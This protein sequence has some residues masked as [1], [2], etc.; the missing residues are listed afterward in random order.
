VSGSLT[1]NAAAT[2]EVQATDFALS[3]TPSS[4]Q[5]FQ[6]GST[7][8]TAT[9]TPQ[10]GFTG[11]VTLGTNGLPT[12]VSAGFSVSTLTSGDS[13]LNLTVS[14]SV[15]PGSYPF[16]IT[17]VSGPITHTAAAT[18]NVQATPDFAVTVTPGTKKV[19]QG[20]H[21]FFTAT[22]TPQ[23]GFSDPVS[24]AVA[25]LPP[26]ATGSF[27]PLVLN[28]GNSTLSIVVGASVAP[29]NYPLDIT[30]AS[31]ILVRNVHVA[32]VVNVQGS[33]T[34]TIEPASQTVTRSSTSTY[35][36]T[37]TPLNGF[38][39]TVDLAVKGTNS[40]I[41]ASLDP[42]SLGPSGTSTLTVNVDAKAARGPHALRVVGTS[43]QLSKFGT[44]ALTVQ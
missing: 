20:G 19:F 26:G 37:V 17:A 32:L 4:Q 29:G 43:G 5:V 10:N 1:H 22:V 42:T 40:H 11:T 44:L 16:T 23:N 7:S 2:L 28:S 25:G 27:S 24:M 35:T 15:T 34:V 14:N 31:G 41:S 12:G 21:T 13:T 36:V 18:L 6:G 9:I 38:H 8:F 39:G 33:F 30:G 3:V